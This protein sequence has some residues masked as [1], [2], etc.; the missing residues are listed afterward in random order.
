MARKSAP[1]NRSCDSP[2]STSARAGIRRIV[3]PLDGSQLSESAL[4]TALSLGRLS[5]ATVHAV[6]VLVPPP[7]DTHVPGLFDT[8]RN[9]EQ[10]FEQQARDYL[11]DVKR[12]YATTGARL[13]VELLGTPASDDSLGDTRAIVKTLGDLVRQREPDLIVMTSHGQGGVRRAWLGSV[14]D[15][16]IRRSGVPVLIVRAPTLVTSPPFTHILV[17]MDGSPLA[18][19][20]L[21]IARQLAALTEARLTVLRVLIPLHAVA[22]PAPV[23]RIDRED[24]ARKR[25][26]AEEHFRRLRSTSGL[27]PN[28]VDTAL[29]VDKNPGQAILDFA[30]THDVDLIAMTTQGLGGVKRLLIGSTADKVVRGATGNVLV[31][32]GQV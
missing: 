30:R 25:A 20:A 31:L 28:G 27:T 21:P 32:R 24:L 17:P 18:D 14:T 5:G 8:K 16:A 9:L 22:K 7:L 3:V 29:V 4:P 1:S 10:T 12:R 2:A 13:V 23:A 6:H 26:D 19:Q 11:E 15:D